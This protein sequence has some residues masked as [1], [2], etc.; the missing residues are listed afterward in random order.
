MLGRYFMLSI[1]VEQNWVHIL[2][3]II[4]KTMNRIFDKFPESFD[5]SRLNSQKRMV[6][7]STFI[8]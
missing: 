3:I 1:S 7:F 5:S 8:F 4:C 2:G 6:T